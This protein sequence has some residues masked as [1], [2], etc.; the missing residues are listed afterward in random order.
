[1]KLTGY[2]TNI[3]EKVLTLSGI[4]PM[5]W[6]LK[7]SYWGVG[8]RRRVSRNKKECTIR[9]TSQTVCKK[10][11]AICDIQSMSGC[12][13]CITALVKKYTFPNG[14]NGEMI[15]GWTITANSIQTIASV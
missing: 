13:V 14:N 11:G 15:A 8:M 3:D 9:H 4:N 10:R 2:I 1:M 12:Y 5:S 6:K 7:D